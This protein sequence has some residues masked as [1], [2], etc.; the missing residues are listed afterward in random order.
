MAVKTKPKP[1]AVAKPM[2]ES[3]GVKVAKFEV[4]KI[5]GDHKAVRKKWHGI[6]EMV[7][8][9][10]NCIWETWLCWHVANHSAAAQ[11]DFLDR[12]AEWKKEKIG[13]KPKCEVTAIPKALDKLIYTTLSKEFPGINTTARMLI[14][15]AVCNKIKS[16]KAAKGS[17][18]G[19]VAIILRNESVPSSTR[20]QPI[21]F[22]KVNAAIVP[23]AV[24]GERYSLKLR[25]DRYDRPGK[26][27][28]AGNEDHIELLTNRRGIKQHEETLRKICAGEYD[29]CGST[30]QWDRKNSKWF[31]LVC[32]RMPVAE[33]SNLDKSK[34]AIL[35][36]GRK[37][38]WSLW[39]ASRWDWLG[40]RGNYVAATRMR[41]LTSRWSRQEN[42]R[43]AGS[44]T[45]GHGR[46][47]ALLAVEKLAQG[48]KNFTK[49]CNHNITSQAVKRCVENGIGRLIYLQPC[50]A[51]SDS[52]FLGYAGKVPG[53]RDSTGWEWHQVATMLAYKCKEA[54]IEFEI[55]KCGVEQAEKQTA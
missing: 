40:G 28:G 22:S 16:R 8:Q 18:P 50:G 24:D 29:F 10:T 42:Y 6:A 43:H 52:R 41:L 51:K 13:E 9:I 21:P 53:R 19:W 26:K 45:K 54:G 38:P 2:L 7:Q 32:Y 14:Q 49:T 25:V 37:E 39:H 44:S 1:K 27:T 3:G 12:H 34:V 5:L 17:L 31:A 46:G 35:H 23:P 15:Y 20:S 30:L 36:P 48:W 11:R 47:R 33:K 55:R 4:Y